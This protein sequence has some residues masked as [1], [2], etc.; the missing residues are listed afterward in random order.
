MKRKE[1]D[2]ESTKKKLK[3]ESEESE[4]DYSVDSEG[5]E[6]EEDKEEIINVDF[7][8]LDYS[9]IDFHGL[10]TL[11]KQIFSTDFTRDS[12]LSDFLISQNIGSVVKV[13][14]GLDP[15][16]FITVL[17]LNSKEEFIT[18]I[19]QF[20][21]KKDD[22]IKEDGACL[23]L[24]CRLINMPPQLAPPLYK[25]L[26]NDIKKKYKTVYYISQVY[27]MVND[28]EV[29]FYQAEDELLQELVDF[30]VDYQLPNPQSSDSR[31]VFNDDGVETWRRIFSFKF[32]KIPKFQELMDK[33]LSE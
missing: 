18:E 13:D 21:K 24:S 29:F 8:F 14:E 19:L 30:Y 20:L 23:L 6:E 28:K 2:L 3:E 11:I 22:R 15:Y 32:D 16:A 27:K 9:E 5:E 26:L 10:K 33:E 12:E 1:S 7:D 31:R 25:Q 4:S 17:D